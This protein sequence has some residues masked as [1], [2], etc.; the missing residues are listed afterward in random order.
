MFLT[1]F[2]I[3]MVTC[4]K[5]LKHLGLDLSTTEAI[6][7]SFITG[8]VIALIGKLALSKIQPDP[9]PTTK[10]RF[11]N[12]EK[13]FGVLCIITA[14]AMAFAHGSNDVANAVGPLAAINS[15][16]ESGGTIVQKSSMP[17][18]DPLSWRGRAS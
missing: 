4:V 18:V 16:V 14:C 6:M 13:V 17:G 5:G 7:Y 2:L 1:G 11:N 9:E 3:A 10:N 12:V 8:A 15:I